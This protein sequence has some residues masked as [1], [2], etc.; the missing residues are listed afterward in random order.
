MAKC[1]M[2][3]KIAFNM[4]CTK[5]FVYVGKNQFVFDL[6][7]KEVFRVGFFFNLFG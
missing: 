5:Y 1:K 4:Y 6:R 2:S 7:R 3:F